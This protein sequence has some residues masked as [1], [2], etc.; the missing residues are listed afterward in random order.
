M[1]IITFMS[2]RKV[3]ALSVY[4][5]HAAYI[6]YKANEVHDNLYVIDYNAVSMTKCQGYADGT[7]QLI[8][9]ERR[10]IKCAPE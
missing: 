9:L 10:F 3:Q 8:L 1:I 4:I 2:L 7:M 5:S 6:I